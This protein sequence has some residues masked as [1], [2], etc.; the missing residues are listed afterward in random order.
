MKSKMI[1]LLM[2][3]TL[4]LYS[5][6][7]KI[8]KDNLKLIR[9]K[10]NSPYP[11]HYK[12]KNWNGKFVPSLNT[13]GYDLVDMKIDTALIYPIVRNAIS[14]R[15]YQQLNKERW[16]IE[17]KLT[18]RGQIVS[19]SFS[20]KDESGVN[21]HEFA[22]LAERIKKEVKWEL[23]LNKEVKDLFY[24]RLSIPGPKL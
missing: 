23:S 1:L 10:I 5:Y 4:G 18:G 21:N 8:E 14:A 19:V 20:F 11:Y 13:L 7:Q 9:E 16:H 24:L 2:V 3:L 15:Y 6:T 17:T 22:I 12:N